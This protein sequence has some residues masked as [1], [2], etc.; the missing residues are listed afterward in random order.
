MALICHRCGR[1]AHV[2]HTDGCDRC[3]ET[4]T[5]AEPAKPLDLSELQ[6]L[7]K[8]M[9]EREFGCVQVAVILGIPVV[10]NPALREGQWFLVCDQKSYE[11]MKG[12][13]RT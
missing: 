7:K 9:A 2:L 1:P 13:F 11:K 3:G 4:H 6:R 8:E 10:A 5:R 12:L